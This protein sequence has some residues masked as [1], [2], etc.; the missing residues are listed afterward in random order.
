MPGPISLRIVYI[1]N[2]EDGSLVVERQR[3]RLP[4]AAVVAFESESDAQRFAQFMANDFQSL[5]IEK[6][7]PEAV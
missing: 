7:N 2:F 1:G 6:A 4:N 3:L 5:A